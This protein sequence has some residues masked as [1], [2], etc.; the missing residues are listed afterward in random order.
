MIVD[1]AL[2]QEAAVRSLLV[3]ARV[4]ISA[5]APLAALPHLLAALHHTSSFHFGLLVGCPPFLSFSALHH[6]S[7]TRFGLWLSLWRHH[8]IRSRYPCK[9]EQSTSKA[10]IQV[11]LD[12]QVCIDPT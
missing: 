3:L 5:G 12:L 1:F 6:N 11:L 8:A 7:S 2:A 10:C 9:Y 4:H